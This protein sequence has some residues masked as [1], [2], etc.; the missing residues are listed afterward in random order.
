MKY[1][2]FILHASK[3][4]KASIINSFRF[5]SY[6]FNYTLIT[7]RAKPHAVCIIL[8]FS[9]L[10]RESCVLTAFHIAIAYKLVPCLQFCFDSPLLNCS[11]ENSE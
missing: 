10:S 6:I 9:V 4:N 8:E 5:K 2:D 3:K 11:S 7:M 1:K